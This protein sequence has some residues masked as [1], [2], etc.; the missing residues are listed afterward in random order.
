MCEPCGP[1]GIASVRRRGARA[2]PGPPARGSGCA[3]PATPSTARRRGSA[4]GSAP[5]S[6]ASAGR[7]EQRERDDRRDRV[8]RAART[9]ACSSRVAEP[10][11]LA[12]LQRDA[13]EPLLDPERRERRLDV[14]V[15]ADRD[16]AGDDDHV[17]AARAPLRAPPRSRARSSGSALGGDATRAAA[18]RERGEHRRVGVVDLA[19]AERL[20]GRPQLVAGAEHRRPAAAGRRVTSPTPARD[21]GA[22]LGDA[23]ARSRARARS[24]PARMSSPAAAD[25]LAGR[26]SRPRSRSVAVAPSTSSWRITASAPGGTAAPVEIRIASP[27]AERAVARRARRATRRRRSS[28]APGGAGA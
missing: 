9:R 10:G 12:G 25:V 21:R 22:E 23:E 8:A 16:P 7:D 28:V 15:G 27:L 2:G 17:G 5:C 4:L 13:P 20:A 18:R 19:R 6:A 24:S 1:L 14:V 11:R 3:A 26:R